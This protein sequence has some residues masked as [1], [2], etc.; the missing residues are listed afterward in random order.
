MKLAE[1]AATECAA[2]ECAA[3]REAL[4]R[5][6]SILRKYRNPPDRI[7]AVKA[8][9][10]KRVRRLQKALAD[11][12]AWR[13]AQNSGAPQQKLISV[14]RS[15]RTLRPALRGRGSS[16]QAPPNSAARRWT[17]SVHHCRSPHA[18]AR[19]DGAPMMALAARCELRGGARQPS[20]F[21]NSVRGALMASLAERT[22]SPW[23]ATS[24]RDRL[25]GC[26]TCASSLCGA[27]CGNG[28]FAGSRRRWFVGA[29]RMAARIR[30]RAAT[31]M[32]LAATRRHRSR[33]GW[34]PLTAFGFA[35]APKRS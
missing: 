8:Y 10:P 13:A 12:V 29:D 33:H 2:T 7:S 15:A 28:R 5:Y 18:R 34:W 32:T 9:A 16:A 1:C 11:Q 4:G 19:G 24:M 30:R 20:G 26:S 17:L 14:G 25:A 31:S 35:R 23:T 3:T 6:C 27:V 21:N 22:A